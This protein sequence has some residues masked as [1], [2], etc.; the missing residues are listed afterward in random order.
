MICAPTRNDFNRGATFLFFKGIGMK[1]SFWKTKN[2]LREA[3]NYKYLQNKLIIAQLFWYFIGI[4]MLVFL[5]GI[6][7]LT[8]IMKVFPRYAPQQKMI[9]LWA[10][11]FCSTKE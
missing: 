7:A 4:G 2:H 9:S 8:K 10:Q 6:T 3:A 5:V 1:C 11:L